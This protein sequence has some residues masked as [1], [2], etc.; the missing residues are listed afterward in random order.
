MDNLTPDLIKHFEKKSS[1]HHYI[2]QFLINGFTDTNGLLFIYDKQIDK[3]LSKQRSP[4]S[5]F[6]EIDR[7]TIELKG[8]IKSSILEDSLYAEI[9][10]MSSKVIKYFQTKSLDEI[11][12]KAEDIATLLF[13]LITLFWRIPKTDYASDGIMDRAIISTTNGD[14]EQLRN[15]PAYRKLSRAGLFRHHIAEMINFGVKKN[16]RN[17]IHQHEKPIY[18]IGDFPFLLRNQVDEFRKFNDEDILF[19]VSSTRLYSSTSESLKNFTQINSYCY[20]AAIINQSIKYIACAELQVLEQSIKIYKELKRVG[21][22]YSNEQV[23]NTK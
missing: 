3:I 20:N 21:L 17:N 1:R 12:F 10:N 16:K 11:D 4:K 22:I 19:A 14:A 13:F 18:V 8:D 5:I 15:S 6:F 7:N 23:F 2:P 9:D